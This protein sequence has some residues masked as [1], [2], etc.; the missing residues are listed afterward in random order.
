M[1]SSSI[2]TL[3]I[4]VVALAP[5]AAGAK[6]VKTFRKFVP[7]EEVQALLDVGTDTHVKIGAS[8]VERIHKVAGIATLACAVDEEDEFVV[9]LK[10]M[11]ESTIV[12]KD[13]FIQRIGEPF[14]RDQVGFLV[15]ESNNATKFVHGGKEVHL[16]KGSL[17]TFAGDVEHNTEI[18]FGHVKIAGPFHVHSMERVG[19]GGYHCW[20]DDPSECDEDLAAGFS[21]GACTIEGEKC[22]PFKQEHGCLAIVGLCYDFGSCRGFFDFFAT[23]KS[24]CLRVPHRSWEELADPHANLFSDV[25][26]TVGECFSA[27]NGASGDPHIKRWTGEKYDYHGECTLVLGEMLLVN[28]LAVCF[29]S[30]TH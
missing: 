7:H 15:L 23:T 21:C 14:V 28:C 8:L 10:T 1:L 3:L 30:F 18:P 9:P 2:R 11:T 17:V 20:V 27:T 6:S 24:D 5:T 12:H 16:E 22:Y 29:Q 4:L 19:H 26:E 13:H 25:V